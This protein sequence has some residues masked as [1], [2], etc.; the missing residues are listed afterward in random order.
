MYDEG[1][2]IL[3]CKI[4]NEAKHNCCGEI[5]APYLVPIATALT[6]IC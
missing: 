4:Q 1:C 5:M 2:E 3:E 6:G